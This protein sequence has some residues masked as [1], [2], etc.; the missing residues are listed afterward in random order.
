MKRVLSCRDHNEPELSLIP[1]R[2]TIQT[3]TSRHL[4]GFLF[5]S[6]ILLASTVIPPHHREIFRLC[7][8]KDLFGIPCPGCGITRAFLFLAHG[9]FRSAMELN[10]NSLLVFSLVVLFWLHSVFNV[11]THNELKIQLTRTESICLV[12]L[13]AIAAASGWI[14]NLKM[15]PW[16]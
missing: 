13:A 11:L 15:N 4:A 1:A 9:D 12:T 10:V 7:L 16:L 6:G 8:L 5:L 2:F 14:Y 3:A